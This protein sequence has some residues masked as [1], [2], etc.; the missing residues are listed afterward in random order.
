MK[1]S[2]NEE[3]MEVLKESFLPTCCAVGE[4]N[5]LK[6]AKFRLLVSVVGRL[7]C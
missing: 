7:I 1:K 5:I 4:F 3:M 2:E 6:L